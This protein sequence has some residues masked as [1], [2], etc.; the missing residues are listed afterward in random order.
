MVAR[1]APPISHSITSRPKVTQNVCLWW[2][3]WATVLLTSAKTSGDAL[4]AMSGR[5]CCVH[6]D[7]APIVPASASVNS[8]KGISALM[9]W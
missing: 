5:R 3:I 7:S 9:T 1:T 8:A 6:S 4:E 2:R